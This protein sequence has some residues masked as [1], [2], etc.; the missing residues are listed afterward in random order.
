MFR[1][2]HMGRMN[3]TEFFTECADTVGEFARLAV[4]PVQEPRGTILDPG[5]TGPPGW[6]VA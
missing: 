4:V 1:V 5:R 3:R 6:Q 2:C